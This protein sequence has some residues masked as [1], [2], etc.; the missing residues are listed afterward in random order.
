M[1]FRDWVRRLSEADGSFRGGV[2]HYFASYYHPL[3]FVFVFVCIA[4]YVYSYL[5]LY[6]RLVGSI[7]GSDSEQNE[8]FVL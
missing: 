8:K 5:P 2:C 1:L 7:N 3:S 6:S 4:L